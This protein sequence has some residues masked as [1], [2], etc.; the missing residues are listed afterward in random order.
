MDGSLGF[1][2]LL[3]LNALW[4]ERT[5]TTAAAARLIQRPEEEARAILGWPG[6]S[7]PRLAAHDEKRE[8]TWRLSAAT[9]RGL[10][11]QPGAYVPATGLRA[12]AAGADGVAVCG[13]AWADHAWKETAVLCRIGPYQ[14]TC[15]LDR[16][17]KR[18]EL[19]RHGQLKGAFYVRVSQKI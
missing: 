12:L 2:E 4:Q 10:G 17:V 14:A 13:A 15:L 5:V 8:R 18:G 11:E 16:L 19:N 7:R 1:N 6:G 3:V 9:Y